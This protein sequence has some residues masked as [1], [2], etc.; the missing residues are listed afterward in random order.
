ME[1]DPGWAAYQEKTKRLIPVVALYEIP[2]DGPPTFN[3]GSLGEAVKVV[4]DAFRRELA[5]L[6]QEIAGQAPPSAPSSAS[7]ASRSATVCT[8]TTPARTWAS[9]R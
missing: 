4:H 9:S 3:A 2:A 1:S 7:T 6:R 8:T 5:L